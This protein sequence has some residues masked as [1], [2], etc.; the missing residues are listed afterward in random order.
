MRRPP[1]PKLGDTIEMYL[2][3]VKPLVPAAAF[4]RTRKEAEKFMV[5]GG[6]GEELQERLVRRAKERTDSS[7]LAEWWTQLVTYK[8][9]EGS[10]VCIAGRYKYMFNACRVPKRLQDTFRKYDPVNHN[11]VVVLRNKKFYE[12]DLVFDRRTLSFEEIQFQLERVIANAGPKE[13]SIGVLS[14]QNRDAWAAAYDQ[15]IHEG[16]GAS[17]NRL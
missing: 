8:E 1:V 5:P 12:F 6:I 2:K 7:W 9:R 16:N 3:S 10:A 11:H 17:L 4:E 13:S 15:V 14:S